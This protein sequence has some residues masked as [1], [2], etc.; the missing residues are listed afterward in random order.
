M[1]LNHKIHQQFDV[2]QR[3]IR[4]TWPIQQSQRFDPTLSDSVDTLRATDQIRFSGFERFTDRVLSW[5]LSLFASKRNPTVG[6]SR[7]NRSPAT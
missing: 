3:A 7:L 4:E 2:Y 6:K 1:S 5:F